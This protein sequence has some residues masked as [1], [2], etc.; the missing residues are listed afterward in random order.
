MQNK[1]L[2]IKIQLGE[3]SYSMNI[4]TENE[5]KIRAAANLVQQ[6]YNKYKEKYQASELEYLAMTTFDI[7]KTNLDLLEKK[8]DHV[9]FTE[10]SDI[11]NT[12]SEYIEAQ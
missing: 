4:N 2:D 12:L 6:K 7:A 8:E 3:K 11:V 10:L 1:K 5:E 9:F